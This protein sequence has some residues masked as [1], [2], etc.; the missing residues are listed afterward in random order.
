MRRSLLAAVGLVMALAAPA[1]AAPKVLLCAADGNQG[2]DVRLRLQA[3]GSFAAVD[4]VDCR[5]STPSLAQLKMYEAVFVYAST[6]YSDR[7]AL[8]NVLADYVD[9]GGGV[10]QSGYAFYSASYALAG[11]WSTE[12]YDC[13]TTAMS[14]FNQTTT[15]A[16]PTDPNSLVVK[17]ITGWTVSTHGQGAVKGNGKAL[18]SYQDATIAVCRTQIKGRERIDINLLPS[19]TKELGPND[20]QKLFTQATLWVSGGFNPLKGTPNPA[21]YPDTGT[22]AISAAKTITFTNSAMGQLNV[23]SAVIGGQDK[24]DFVI[25]KAPAF[26]L[27]VAPGAT[28]T[29]DVAFQPTVGGDRS[30]T[31]Q[32]A[33]AG[34]MSTADV[35]LAGKAV[36]AQLSITPN[37]LD[38]GGAQIGGS[39]S[40]VVTFANNGGG[41]ITVTNVDITMGKPEF[42]LKTPVMFPIALAG[43]SSFQVTITYTPKIDGKATGVLTVT[44][45][46]PNAPT[47]NIPITSYAGKPAIDVDAGTIAFGNVNVGASSNVNSLGILNSGFSDLRVTD[48]Q[49]GGPNAGDFV[50]DKAM[51]VGALV[52]PFGSTKVL[53]TFKPTVVGNRAATITITSNAGS[54]VVNLFGTGT[55]AKLGVTPMAPLAFGNQKVKQK[56]MAQNVTI[57]NTGSGRLKVLAA[58]IG[59]KDAMSFLQASGPNAPFDVDANSS[60]VLGIACSPQA[61]GPLA[62]TLTILADVGMAVLSLTCNGVAPMVTVTPNKL[63]FGGVPV[64]QKSAPK[65]FTIGNSGTD[66]LNVTGLLITG[67]NLN[68]FD[69]AVQPKLPFAI[70]PKATAAIQ[71]TFTPND[72]AMESASVDLVSDD[73]LMPNVKIPLT[74]TGLQPGFEIDK[75]DLDFGTVMVGGVATRDLVIKNSGDGPITISRISTDGMAKAY[76]SVDRASNITIADGKSQ[77]VKVSFQPQMGGLAEAKLVITPSVAQLESATVTLTGTGVAPSLG[78]APMSLDFGPVPVGTT[79]APL[80]V[81]LTNG[82]GM[83]AVDKIAV[84]GDPSF[85]IDTSA[86]QLALGPSQ[87]TTFTVTFAPVEARVANASIGVSLKGAVMPAVKLQVTGQGVMP[88]SRGT[89][90]CTVAASRRSEGAVALL[91]SL[92]GLA[93]LRR[94]RR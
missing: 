66:A 63:D 11:R 61:L 21:T 48:V 79:S 74:G 49:L 1:L 40:K 62:A 27:A 41:K 54:K 89:G 80:T 25:T 23:T 93:L 60:A 22:G 90:G 37:P 19:T 53:V 47:I 88:K 65:T 58:T 39:V 15:T 73:P 67:A 29:V 33:V 2:N 70:N 85:T 24:G 18:W 32:L 50:L 72:H 77:T 76:Y 13:I 14:N 69:F 78:L 44:T 6:T 38:L 68:D 12:S 5:L 51:A 81:T 7:T 71:V 10:V 84:A 87:G 17:G 64:M 75:M 57:S 16:M 56:S 31:L 9:A 35:A 94:R 45:N 92:C 36:G 59:G 82:V 34:E 83:V 55:S 4:F 26:P 20:L 28:I 43:G 42:S 8:G 3:S 46:D 30:A 91:L 52:P 86:T